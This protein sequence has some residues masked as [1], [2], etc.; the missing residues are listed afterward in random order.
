MTNPDRVHESKTAYVN[1]NREKHYAAVRRYHEA[2]PHKRN[3]A[4]AR[5]YA[6]RKQAVPPWASAE[7]ISWF[8]LCAR[9]VTEETGVPHEVDHIIPLRGK[10]VSG[11]H[12][13][14]NLQ[15]IPA[16]ENRR[17]Q[18]RFDLDNY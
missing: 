10:L 1:A 12:V 18:A 13:E 16:M 5:R 15:V 8:Y 7:A 14:T 3:A 6:R 2:N 4:T 17:K 9:A 11:L